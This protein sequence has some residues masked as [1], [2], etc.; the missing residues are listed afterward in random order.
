METTTIAHDQQTLVV[1]GLVRDNITISERKVPFFGDIPWLGWLFKSQTRTVEK[2]NL[3]VFL[4]PH[5]VRDDADIIELNARKAREINT[6]QRDNR[7][8]EPTR[9][10]QDIL[11]RL[12]RPITPP[13]S[14][15]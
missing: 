6:L 10:K 1:G 12:E 14:P 8:E 9:L 7:I 4:T 11:E 15:R 3:L 13:N 5:L 2:L